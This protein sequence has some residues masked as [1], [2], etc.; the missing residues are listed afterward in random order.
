M[1]R[2]FIPGPVDVDPEVAAAQTKEMLPHRSE[3]FETLYRRTWEKASHL[4][5]T[6]QRVF[7]TASSGTG[8][9]ETAV[10]N[11][12]RETILSCVNGAFSQRW[13]DVALTNGKEADKLEVAWGEPILPDMVTAALQKKPYEIITIVH[14]ETSTGLENPVREIAA[15][16]QETSP[17]TLVCVDAVS[18][19]GGVE[20]DMDA[21]GLDFVLGSS[22]KCIALPPGL[23]LAAVSDRAMARVKQVPNRGWYF[24]LARL[25]RHLLKDSTPATP[26]LSLIYAL[27][28]QLDRILAEGLENRFARHSDMATRVQE[29]SLEQGLDPFAAQ[30]YRSKTVTAVTNTLNLDIVALNKFLMKKDMLIADGYGQLKDRTFRIA[31]MGETQMKDLEQVLKRIEKFIQSKATK[32][33]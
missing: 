13:H 11:L 5:A 17:E 12:A 10:R 8:L 24:D 30:G 22:Q 20:I 6:S 33:D 29:W 15:A 23:A 14:N 27:D 7:I 28:V 1:T 3:E 32:G 26:A 19:L 9:Q 21:W 2:L 4:F 25:E 31:H 18:S 16:V